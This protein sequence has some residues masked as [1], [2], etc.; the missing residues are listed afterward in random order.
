ML[1]LS[2]P[3]PGIHT[4]T[5]TPISLTEIELFTRHVHIFRANSMKFLLIG[6]P[7]NQIHC[8]SWQPD[9]LDTAGQR[10]ETPHRACCALETTARPCS[11]AIGGSKSLLGRASK[12]L[13]ARNRCSSR[14]LCIRQHSKTLPQRS[15]FAYFARVDC[16]GVLRSD[17]ALEI[18]ARA[19]SEAT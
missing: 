13:S 18:S 2:G 17:W 1:E 6:R 9:W 3:I 11:T 14:L 7:H 8:S 4:K 12:P 15:F 5:L 16:S 19:C 10:S